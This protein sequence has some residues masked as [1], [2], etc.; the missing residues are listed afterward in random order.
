MKKLIG[1]VAILFAVM[2]LTIATAVPAF[3]SGHGVQGE[4]Q[5]NQNDD[6]NDGNGGD[7]GGDNDGANG[8]NNGDNG[9]G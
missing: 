5:A 6:G 2:A 7:N 3:A 4:S 1:I 9:D 8:D